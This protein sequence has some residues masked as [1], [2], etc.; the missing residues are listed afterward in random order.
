MSLSQ[1]ETVRGDELRLS[2]TASAARKNDKRRTNCANPTIL[3]QG[4]RPSKTASNETNLSSTR[5]PA[6]LALMSAAARGIM[7]A[8]GVWSKDQKFLVPSRG[9]DHMDARRGVNQSSRH[10]RNVLLRG[11]GYS[12]NSKG[13]VG[14]LKQIWLT[15]GSKDSYVSALIASGHAR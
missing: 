12:A 8:A 11:L 4:R 10:D 13:C 6:A 2:G 15:K 1:S 14:V 7:P 5:R 9:R 3:M